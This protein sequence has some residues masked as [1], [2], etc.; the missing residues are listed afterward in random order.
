MLCIMF[1]KD[2]MI[3]CWGRK[4]HKQQWRYSAT[5]QKH[6]CVEVSTHKTKHMNMKVSLNVS[7]DGV[8]Q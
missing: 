2:M 7:V 5:G 8:L 1:Y 4:Y 6:I 3:I